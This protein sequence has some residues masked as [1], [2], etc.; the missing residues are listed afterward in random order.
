MSSLAHRFAVA[1]GILALAAPA[2]GGDPYLGLAR[3]LTAA[4]K[5]GQVRRAA[6]IGF[7]SAGAQDNEGGMILAE[8]LVSRLAQLGG[9]DVV[10]RTLLDKVLDEQKLGGLGVVDPRQA[11]EVGRMLGVDAIITGTFVTLNDRRVEVHAR[12]IDARS[13]RVLGAASVRVEKEWEQES[14]PVGALW[15]VRAPDPARFPAPLVRLVPDPFRDAPNDRSCSGWE[16]EAG[17]LQEETMELK[18][19]FWAARLLDPRFDPRSV[20]HNPGSDIRS[21]ALR[22]EFYRLVR[23]NKLLGVDPLDRAERDSMESVDARVAD[24]VE[25]CY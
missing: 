23:A 13:A 15:D 2:W 16:E 12:I 1:A 14:M 6:V 20:T 5:H 17:R 3:E 10:E 7:T 22:Q 21:N 24:L 4:A 19:R 25:R 11:G 9:M 18:A 8:R